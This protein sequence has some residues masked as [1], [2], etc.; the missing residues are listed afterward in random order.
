MCL[1]AVF[2]R[3]RARLPRFSTVSTGCG[4]NKE[5]LKKVILFFQSRSN[6]SKKNYLFLIRVSNSPPLER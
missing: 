1:K 2:H 3:H 6:L 5:I 4:K